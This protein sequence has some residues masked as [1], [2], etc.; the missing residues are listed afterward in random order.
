MKMFITV[1]NSNV[2][3][4]KTFFFNKLR[5][6]SPFSTSFFFA[7]NQYY[8][9]HCTTSLI[10]SLVITFFEKKKKID[11][12][13]KNWYIIH[14]VRLNFRTYYTRKYIILVVWRFSFVV[15]HGGHFDFGWSFSSSRGI[16]ILIFVRGYF[17]SL[18][19]SSQ[20]RVLSLLKTKIIRPSCRRFIDGEKNGDSGCSRAKRSTL[21]YL[22][23]KRLITRTVDI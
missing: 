6:K 17:F 21:L 2:P 20:T 13:H 8:R 19:F 5:W 3:S 9:E 10:K 15:R 1:Y 14:L 12:N 4:M 16:F 11:F 7:I 22:F 23:V 18:P